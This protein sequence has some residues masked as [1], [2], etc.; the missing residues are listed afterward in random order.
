VSLVGAL[1]RGW[2]VFTDSNTCGHLH[3][4]MRMKEA[5]FSPRVP[6]FKEIGGEFSY[7][8]FIEKKKQNLHWSSISSTKFDH[9]V[10]R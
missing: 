7:C 4:P 5:K 9:E 8:V 6:F 1:G 10:I 3:G 2:Q